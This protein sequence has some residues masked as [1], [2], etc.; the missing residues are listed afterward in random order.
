MQPR[1]GARGDGAGRWVLLRRKVAQNWPLGDVDPT[2][3]AVV[4]ESA[5]L[6]VLAI[7]RWR[8]PA[9]RVSLRLNAKAPTNEDADGTIQ[10]AMQAKEGP[11]T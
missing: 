7:A 6:G 1:R 11:M 9:S 10:C 3:R 2:P 5:G 4:R 8:P